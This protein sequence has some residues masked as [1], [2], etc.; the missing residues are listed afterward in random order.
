[1]GCNCSVDLREGGRESAKASLTFGSMI[2][3]RSNRPR[4]PP[5]SCMS[6]WCE[7]RLEAPFSHPFVAGTSS[8]FGNL[9]G[10]ERES[11]RAQRESLYP[12]VATGEKWSHGV[13]WW[14]W[15]RRERRIGR[16]G[17]ASRDNTGRSS[18]RQAVGNLHEDEDLPRR[19]LGQPVVAADLVDIRAVYEGPAALEAAKMRR[20]CLEVGAT[21]V[22][23]QHLR[24]AGCGLDASH[25]LLD[26]LPPAEEL[27]NY[28]RGRC[29]GPGTLGLEEGGEGVKGRYLSAR[30]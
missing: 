6:G 28:R 24:R 27:Q 15:G 23:D 20:P 8:S 10:S 9:W 16:G 3:P 7:N 29:S 4:R 26:V 13:W 18:G 12:G 17:E 25:D 5:R 21:V 30:E 19:Q 14:W 22:V 2:F 11:E 1:M